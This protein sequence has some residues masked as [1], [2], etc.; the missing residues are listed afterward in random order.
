MN[1]SR[2]AVVLLSG[3]LDS[4]VAL[5]LCREQGFAPN[6]LTVDYG[7]RH[8]L[9]LAAA[10]QIAAALQIA[11]HV[12]LNVDLTQWGGSALTGDA[13]VPENRPLGDMGKDI[14]TTYVPARNTIF[15][16]LAM[17][18]AETLGTGDIFIGAHSLDY[19]GYPDCRPEYF[20]AFTSMAALATKSGIEGKSPWQIHTP[21]LHL[22]K[23]E[24]VRTG[25]ELSVPFEFTLSCY[26]PRGSTLTD[27]AACGV[28]DACL[29]RR[30]AFTDLGLIDPIRYLRPGEAAR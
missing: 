13:A 4:A 6:A 11:R 5:A 28:C 22:T 24:I 12:V 21:L 30:R 14:P 18:W 2:P 26:Q 17:G 10:R 1:A 16:S 15:L 23:T 20:A 27:W 19:S 9:E 8:R 7:Q 3:G 25:S 29:L